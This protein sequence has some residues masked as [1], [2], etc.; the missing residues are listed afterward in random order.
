M[1]KREMRMLWWNDDLQTGIKSIDDQHKAIFSKAN[2]IFD[3]GINTKKEDLKKIINFLMSYTNNHFLEEEQLMIESGYNKFMEHKQ[4]HNLF[5]EEIYK[6]Y[7]RVENDEIN[8]DLF[9]DL[10]IMIIEWL[11]KH[12]N[13][14]DK[15]FVKYFKT[16]R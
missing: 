8:E 4:Q 1:M 9:D 14:S 11:T 5:V 13:N 16:A 6:V 12:I 10:K 15:D 7:L 2:E 3:I